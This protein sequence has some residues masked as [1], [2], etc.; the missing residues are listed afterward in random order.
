MKDIDREEFG[1]VMIGLQEMYGK[2]LGLGAVGLYFNALRVWSIEDVKTA[3]ERLIQ[4]CEFMPRPV[5]FWRL[6]DA[7][8]PAAGEVFATVG[9]WLIYSPQGYT[10][11]AD[12]PRPI[13][14]AIAAMGGANAYAMCEETK[15]PFLEKRF[16][17]HYDQI[18]GVEDTRRAVPGIAFEGD[19]D[20]LE[21]DG[22]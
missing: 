20:L 15:L 9:K 21:F 2:T 8:K 4:T 18:T 3:A 6:R 12:T 1:K 14:A 22:E 11:R 17:Q 19:T 5:D 13:A 7:G 10:V 16:C